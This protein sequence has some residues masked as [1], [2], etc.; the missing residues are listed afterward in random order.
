MDSWGTGKKAG[1]LTRSVSRQALNADAM[2]EEAADRA[3]AFSESLPSGMNQEDI[4]KIGQ[5]DRGAVRSGASESAGA[6]TAVAIAGATELAKQY[7]LKKLG[8]KVVETV[9]GAGTRLAR[10]FR[11]GSSGVKSPSFA[12]TEPVA[13]TGRRAIDLGHSY[14]RSVR[15]LYGDV[16]FSR[17]RYVAIVNGRRVSGVADNVA[18]IGGRDVAVEAKHVD[19]W[20]SSLRNPANQQPWAVGEQRQMVA[21]A[22]QYSNAFSEVVYHTNSP[23]LAAHYSSEFSR[24]GVSNFRFVITPTVR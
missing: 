9:T 15:R 20:A 24:V 6:F 7:G 3:R 4:R 18:V 16:P 22:Q 10:V 13:A 5:G 23:E 1:T 12:T 11:R 2:S 8:E 21:Q 19:D 17:R 14:E